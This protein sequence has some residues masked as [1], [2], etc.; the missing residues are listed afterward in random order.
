MIP[1]LYVR[2]LKHDKAAREESHGQSDRVQ[3]ANCLLDMVE[4]T[5]SIM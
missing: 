4:T 1:A 3:L 2:Y 5:V